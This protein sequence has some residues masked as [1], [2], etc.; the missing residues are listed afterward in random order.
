MHECK[1]ASKDTKTNARKHSNIQEYKKASMQR[2]KDKKQCCK[3][4]RIHI[5]MQ[6]CRDG[7]VEE[8]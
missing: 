5:R 7:R 6:G 8:C 3:N 4:S 2:C 1:D